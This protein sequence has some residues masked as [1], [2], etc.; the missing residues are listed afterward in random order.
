VASK[1][2]ERSKRAVRRRNATG[3]SGHTIFFGSLRSPMTNGHGG[4]RQAG[5]GKK[6]GAGTANSRLAKGGAQGVPSVLTMFSQGGSSSSHGAGSSSI[7]AAEAAVEPAAPV[8]GVR[9]REAGGT[10]TKAASTKQKIEAAAAGAE[11]MPS[12]SG[13]DG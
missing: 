5:P 6:M 4:P 13:S 3:R 9:A 8:S 7:S 11:P 2:A 12:G 1:I 10:P